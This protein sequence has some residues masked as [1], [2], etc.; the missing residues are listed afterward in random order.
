MLHVVGVAVAVCGF[1][2]VCV[3]VRCSIHSLQTIYLFDS[4]RNGRHS[5]DCQRSQDIFMYRKYLT[6]QKPNNNSSSLSII[7]MCT[8]WA[9]LV[10]RRTGKW[11]TQKN[12][13]AKHEWNGINFVSE[14]RRITTDNTTQQNSWN[15]YFCLF[16]NASDRCTEQ[17]MANVVHHPP[18]H[19]L[20]I[21]MIMNLMRR[22]QKANIKPTDRVYWMW[23]SYY[24]HR[25]DINKP[26]P[27]PRTA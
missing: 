9:S 22:A 27:L 13:L 10:S 17:M 2:R 24:H 19:S 1:V 14:A 18:H 8:T 16:L 11:H 3:C 21:M 23:N 12:S 15:Y 26:L 7:Y 5:F 20:M 6:Q 4:A 25:N